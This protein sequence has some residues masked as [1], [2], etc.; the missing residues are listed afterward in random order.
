MDRQTPDPLSPLEARARLRAAASRGLILPWARSRPKEA[1][2]AAFL[3]GFL[4]G[5]SPR[6]GELARDVV[7]ALLR[8]C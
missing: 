7:L 4:V 1:A 5:S 6:P 3:A 2:V 8:R